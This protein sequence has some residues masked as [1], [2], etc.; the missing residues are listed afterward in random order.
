M[1]QC[2]CYTIVE[3]NP[4]LTVYD[5]VGP[6]KTIYANFS[7][8]NIRKF[9]QNT[10][11]QCVGTSFTAIIDKANGIWVFSL[12]SEN[13][14]N[15][16]R[17]CKMWC[18]YSLFITWIIF[19]T[20]S[21]N[22]MKSICVPANST[23][24]LVQCPKSRQN[25]VKPWFKNH[26]AIGTPPSSFWEYANLSKNRRQIIADAFHWFRAHSGINFDV[27]K[28]GRISRGVFPK[29]SDPNVYP[30]FLRIFRT[31]YCR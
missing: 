13:L 12:P 29:G 17:I 3:E 22:I 5:V 8:S 21:K 9:R 6:S 28:L 4:W 2:I 16:M 7:Q 10:G 25:S 23:S 1:L 30:A 27:P 15:V 14:Q 11:E 31:G 19:V 20:W 24:I 26:A 18:Y